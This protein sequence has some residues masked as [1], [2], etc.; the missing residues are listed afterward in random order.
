MDPRGPCKLLTHV[1]ASCV[2]GLTGK[3]SLHRCGV[4]VVVLLETLATRVVEGVE[5]DSAVGGCEG[6]EGEKGVEELHCSCWCWLEAW[7]C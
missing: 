2:Y 5:A 7:L 1:V 3:V 6:Q 4:E